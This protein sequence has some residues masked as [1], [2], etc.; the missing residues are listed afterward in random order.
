M[1]PSRVK[2][3]CWWVGF[4]LFWLEQTRLERWTDPSGTSRVGRR[5]GGSRWNFEARSAALGSQGTP[6]GDRGGR[7]FP[8]LSG[9][10]LQSCKNHRKQSTSGNWPG[11]AV[12]GLE[13]ITVD[14]DGM[15]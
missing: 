4:G 13:F 8:E 10:P 14:S 6:L 7:L 15:F 1:G 3:D 12:F 11:W 2:L 5:H 9:G